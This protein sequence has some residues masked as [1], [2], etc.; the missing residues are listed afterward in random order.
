VFARTLGAI[1]ILAVFTLGLDLVGKRMLRRTEVDAVDQVAGASIGLVRGFVFAVLTVVIASGA[2]TTSG[3]GSMAAN[4]VF[5][6]F[7]TEPDG[8][9]LG[10]FEAATGDTQ[11]VE[12]IRFN[13]QFPNGSLVSEG[14]RVIPPTALADLELDP[15]AGVEITLLLNE[16]RTEAGRAPLDWSSALSAVAQAYAEEMATAGFFSHDSPTTGDVGD[17]LRNAGIGFRVAGENLG[18]APTVERVHDGWLNS[19]PHRSNILAPSFTRVGIG[20]VRTPLGLMAVQV[21]QG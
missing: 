9:P 20:V 7:V 16:A 6:G 8:T 18:L 11:L 4:S 14:F 19:P 1:V 5:A 3:I 15:Q 2:V 10:M 17:R 13:R 12:V 21:F